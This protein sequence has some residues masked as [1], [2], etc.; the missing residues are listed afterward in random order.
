MGTC[1]EFRSRAM[2]TGGRWVS[3]VPIMPSLR[4]TWFLEQ[5]VTFEPLEPFSGSVNY[6]MADQR[7]AITP[8]TFQSIN[9]EG[10]AG[11]TCRH[12]YHMSCIIWYS[13]WYLTSI[14]WQNCI[15]LIAL[16]PYKP[17]P[18]ETFNV[19]INF[20]LCGSCCF[21]TGCSCALQSIWQHTKYPWPSSARS[22]LS[23]SPPTALA[24]N[25]WKMAQEFFTL[26]RAEKH[27]TCDILY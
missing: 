16:A 20:N 25:I 26:N 21:L 10:V 3:S 22:S 17:S 8:L 5:L 23:I 1:M 13:M 12:R 11:H 14:P 9:F 4:T 27:V 19:A 18:P 2:Q 24:S 7:R 6:I 15:C